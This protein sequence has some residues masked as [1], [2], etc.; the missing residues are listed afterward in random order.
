MGST[1]FHDPERPW[2]LGEGFTWLPD[3]EVVVGTLEP[4]LATALKDW[5]LAYDFWLHEDTELARSMVAF[6][7]NADC[8]DSSLEAMF[9]ADLRTVAQWREKADEAKGRFY[10]LLLEAA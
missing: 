3:G 1:V 2:L 4:S 10:R 8:V 7:S 5:Q 6:D 9:A